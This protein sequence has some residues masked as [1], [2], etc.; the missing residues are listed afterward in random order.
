M[1]IAMVIAAPTTPD[2]ARAQGASGMLSQVRDAFQAGDARSLLEHGAD[3]VEITFFGVSTTY[4]RSQ[5][6]YVMGDFF[7]QFRPSH[8]EL[9]ESSRASGHWFISGSYWYHRGSQPLQVMVRFRAKDNGWELREIRVA[10]Q[11]RD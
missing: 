5:S 3:R 2:L 11:A 6:A 7:R 8:V 1:A 4:T 10:A 9:Y